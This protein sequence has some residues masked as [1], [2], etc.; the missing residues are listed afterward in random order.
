[1]ATLLLLFNSSVINYQSDAYTQPNTHTMSSLSDTNEAV[2]DL[3]GR[4][5]ISTVTSTYPVRCSVGII[6]TS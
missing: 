5:H 2:R 6:D 1:M 3:K 4:H